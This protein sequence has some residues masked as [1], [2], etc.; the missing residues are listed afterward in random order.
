MNSKIYKEVR[1]KLHLLNNPK[2]EKGIQRINA[3]RKK[4][5]KWD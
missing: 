1:L 2:K 5:K 4:T 3:G